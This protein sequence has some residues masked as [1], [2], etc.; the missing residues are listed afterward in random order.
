[1]NK[2][3]LHTPAQVEIKLKEYTAEIQ[4]L[5]K[6]SEK[7]DK[8]FNRYVADAKR[9]IELS[10]KKVPPLAEQIENNVRSIMGD[11]RPMDEVEKEIKAER[12]K[13]VKKAFS[14]VSKRFIRIGA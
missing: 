7:M 8:E 4:R 2:L 1:M 3:D 12:E 6:E 10:K 13:S 5:K 11:L 14:V 9:E